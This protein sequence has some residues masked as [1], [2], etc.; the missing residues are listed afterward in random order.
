MR[1]IVE[2][3]EGRGYGYARGGQ[4]MDVAM[5][6]DEDDNVQ[7]QADV[8]A[9][10]QDLPVPQYDN[11][12][13]SEHGE[14]DAIC[15]RATSPEVIE[16]DE[17]VPLDSEPDGGGSTRSRRALAQKAAAVSLGMTPSP[18]PSMRANGHRTPSPSSKRMPGGVD[19]QVKLS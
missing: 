3:E 6:L 13:G 16:I 19:A 12:S 7:E 2:D 18:G 8:D 14:R 11:T 5:V 4:S 10:D 17:P 1:R 9:M 15:G